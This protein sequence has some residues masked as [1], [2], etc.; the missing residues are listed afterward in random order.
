MRPVLIA[1]LALSFLSGC[2][3]PVAAPTAMKAGVLAAKKNT[4]TKS[5]VVTV[6]ASVFAYMED[7]HAQL[8]EK[9]AD[10]DTKV[11]VTVTLVASRDGFKRE[12]L[13]AKLP[14]EAFEETGTDRAFVLG[15]LNGGVQ[16]GEYTYYMVMTGMVVRQGQTRAYMDTLPDFYVSDHGKNY[17]TTLK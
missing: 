6:P 4:S 5:A 8:L 15:M 10:A 14:K 11:H 9:Y 13:E 3:A 2:T 7:H 17:R 16:P 1:L 12:R